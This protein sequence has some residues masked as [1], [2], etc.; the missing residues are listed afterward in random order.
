MLFGYHWLVLAVVGSFVPRSRADKGFPYGA[1][2]FLAQY[3]WLD[4]FAPVA[5]LPPMMRDGQNLDG[6]I[7]L[8]VDDI[9]MKNPEHSAPDVGC[10]DDARAVGRRA[11]LRQHLK[12]ISVV[13]SP[14]ASL[15]L[16]VVRDLLGVLGGRLGVEPIPHRNR[17]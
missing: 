6:A 14:Q 17:A 5:R 15:S 3:V 12:K 16:F 4:P 8:A 10:S 9:E 13:A 11:D 2:Q 7:D 1:C